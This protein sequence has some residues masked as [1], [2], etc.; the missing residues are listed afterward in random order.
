MVS[1]M[2]NLR[3]MRNCFAILTCLYY[4]IFSTKIV[5]FPQIL[6]KIHTFF[7]DM[8]QSAVGGICRSLRR[9]AAGYGYP[10]A[11]AVGCVPRKS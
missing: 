9:R 7:M 1:I 4:N 2:R 5:H 10:M 8:N 11:P 3:P 6:Q